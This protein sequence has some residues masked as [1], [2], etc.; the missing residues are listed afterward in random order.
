MLA[1]YLISILKVFGFLA[2]NEK[3]TGKLQSF[4]D[5]YDN[6]SNH[7]DDHDHNYRH[8]HDVTIMIITIIMIINDQ[9][10]S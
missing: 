6:H 1:S 4:V 5:H 7:H 3:T 2:S 8:D 9:P 10:T